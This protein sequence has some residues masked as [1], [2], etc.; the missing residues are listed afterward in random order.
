MPRKFL[1]LYNKDKQHPSFHINSHTNLSIS[2]KTREEHHP[3]NLASR[4]NPCIASSNIQGRVKNQNQR[5]RHEL[6][7]FS[8][9]TIDKRQ[10]LEEKGLER[11]GRA[12][13]SNWLRI[14]LPVLNLNKRQLVADKALRSQQTPSYRLAVSVA[15]FLLGE[16]EGQAGKV[17]ATGVETRS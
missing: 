5:E 17:F 13:Q 14:D 10:E 3:R 1:R 9:E 15:I 7:S 12:V 2:S 8:T 6:M 11:E 4:Q 16:L